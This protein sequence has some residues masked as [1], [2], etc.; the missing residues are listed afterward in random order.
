MVVNVSSI[1]SVSA[2]DRL[3]CAA[4]CAEPVSEQVP[5]RVRGYV[6]FVN[7]FSFFSSPESKIS[8]SFSILSC[9]ATHSSSCARLGSPGTSVADARTASN[10]AKTSMGGR[11]SRNYNTVSATQNILLLCVP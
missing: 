4:A 11:L 6:P 8:V 1:K 10:P 5:G 2:G 9:S 3:R 7:F